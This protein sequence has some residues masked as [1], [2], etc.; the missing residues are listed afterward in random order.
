MSDTTV[1]PPATPMTPD[2]ALAKLMA[3][4]GAAETALRKFVA[5]VEDVTHAEASGVRGLA[6]TLLATL[7]AGKP[8]AA[9][10][11]NPGV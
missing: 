3:S 4:Y 2:A 7:R 6:A 9:K 10:A 11:G 8:E 5:D 1:Q